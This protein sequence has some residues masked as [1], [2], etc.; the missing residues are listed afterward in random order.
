MCADFG[1][2]P[3]SDPLRGPPAPARGEGSDVANRP[4]DEPTAEHAAGLLGG[5]EDAGLAGGDA[6]LRLVQQ[7]LGTAVGLELEPRQLGHPLDE[8]GDLLAEH[9]PRANVEVWAWVLMPNHVH[10]LVTGAQADIF[11]HYGISMEGLA[12]T[13]R[14]LDWLDAFEHAEPQAHRDRDRVGQQQK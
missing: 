4:L 12:A 5:V 14:G 7:H 3:L 8:G 10:L 9:A 6:A 11:R 1:A 2:G 13:A